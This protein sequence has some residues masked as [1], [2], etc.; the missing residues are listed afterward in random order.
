MQIYLENETSSTSGTGSSTGS[1]MF[2]QV[3]NGLKGFI[4]RPRLTKLAF[5]KGQI[6]IKRE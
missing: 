5:I 3:Y 2:A 4:I 6:I 1:R